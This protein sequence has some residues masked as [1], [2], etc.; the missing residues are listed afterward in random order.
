MKLM[1][2]NI[3]M[4]RPVPHEGRV[5]STGI[6]KEPVVGPILLRHLNL[7]GDGQAD[8]R[9][10]GGADKAVYAYPFE[11]YAFWE[12]ELGRDDFS[13]G[14]FGENFT[15]TGWLEDTVCIGD[16]FQIG[17][18][19]VQVTQPRSPCFKLGIRMGDDQ[20]PARFATANRTGFYLRVLQEGRVAAGDAIERVAHDADSLCVSDVFRLRHD[21]GTR[22]E[23]ERAARLPALSPSWRAVF[24][25]RLLEND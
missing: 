20:F 23:Y 2:V 22:E 7:D 13:H 9:V 6:F 3:G 16:E 4:P 25:K 18:A 1:S 19:R 15:I 11:H 17:K 21:R 24:E 5:V 14:H 8:L 12:A 10:H